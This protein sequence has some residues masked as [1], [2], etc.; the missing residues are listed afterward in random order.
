MYVHENEKIDYFLSSEKNTKMFCKVQGCRYPN[1]HVS[2]GHECGK[3][4]QYGHGQYECS[5]RENITYSLTDRI[6]RDNWC[7]I[8]GCNY[9]Q[10]HVTMGHFCGTCRKW[11]DACLCALKTVKCPVCRTENKYANVDS[12]KIFGISQK[13]SICMEKDI[14]V[15]LPICKHA[16]LCKSC[17]STITNG[18]QKDELDH[19]MS[20]AQERLGNRNNVYV[21]EY[22][23]QGCVWYMKRV[24]DEITGFFLHGDNHGQYGEET[25]DIPRLEEFLSGCTEMS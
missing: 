16:C 8:T 3:C 9:K 25:N 15:C 10:Y 11:G 17:L 6:P 20:S 24:G 5:R 19:V 2:V 12:L 18:E 1:F 13:C 7:Q 23:G 14:E 21:V 4:H 22:V